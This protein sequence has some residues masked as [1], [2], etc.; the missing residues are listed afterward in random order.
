[1]ERGSV[2]EIRA[3]SGR[4]KRTDGAN[5]G[6]VCSEVKEKEWGEAEMVSRMVR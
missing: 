6:S 2:V 3:M 5:G 4:V 1:M